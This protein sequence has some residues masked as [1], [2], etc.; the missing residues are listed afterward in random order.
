MKL[1]PSA[2]GENTAMRHWLGA[3]SAVHAQ[4]H[5]SVVKPRRWNIDTNG[6]VSPVKLVLI[7]P[8]ASVSVS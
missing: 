1:P 3:R 7:Q 5:H 4:I 2:S 8:Q 6:Q